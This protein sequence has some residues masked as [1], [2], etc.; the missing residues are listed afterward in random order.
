MLA[1]DITAA[2]E[3]GAP[4]RESEFSKWVAMRLRAE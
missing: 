3:A 2:V 1:R 4:E